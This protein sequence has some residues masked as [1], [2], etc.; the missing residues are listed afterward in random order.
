M[1]TV[2]NVTEARL[3]VAQVTEDEIIAHLMDGKRLAPLPHVP[4]RLVRSAALASA[5]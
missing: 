3:L 5:G 1:N 4:S 2:G